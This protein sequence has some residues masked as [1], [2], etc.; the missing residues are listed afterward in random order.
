MDNKNWFSGIFGFGKKESKDSTISSDEENGEDN[1]KEVKKVDKVEDVG[2]EKRTSSREE[3]EINV[4]LNQIEELKKQLANIDNQID[5]TRGD[6]D[7]E[8]D[9]ARRQILEEIDKL[10]K[11]AGIEVSLDDVEYEKAEIEDR[12]EVRKIVDDIL[13][14]TYILEAERVKG[15]SGKKAKMAADLENLFG[16]DMVTTEDIGG[17]KRIK[18]IKFVE[19]EKEF[20]KLTKVDRKRKIRN[21]VYKIIG[22]ILTGV[23][24]GFLA[25]T[26]Y[27]LAA[28][29]F[30][31][32]AGGSL[33][34]NG[35]A[36]FAA[37]LDLEKTR[38]NSR[39]TIERDDYIR[40]KKAIDLARKV[41]KGGYK[42]GEAVVEL[43]EYIQKSE[44][45]SLEK[46]KAFKKMENVDKWVKAGAGFVGG[47]SAS[48]GSFL[49]A[50]GGILKEIM[51]KGFDFDGDG[52]LHALRKLKDGY[53]FVYNGADETTQ[54]ARKVAEKTLTDQGKT[55]T[56]ASI[57]KYAGE[58]M[59]KLT[60]LNL[61]GGG[62]GHMLKNTESVNRAI[63]T[64]LNSSKEYIQL[65]YALSG[66]IIASIMNGLSLRGMNKENTLDKD[67]STMF[68]ELTEKYRERSGM[69][70]EAK[71]K[72]K[73][74]R[75][76]AEE[77]K[78]QEPFYQAKEGDMI[79]I[80]TPIKGR[81]E[82]YPI[83][84]ELGELKSDDEN[85]DY[86]PT[87][88]NNEDQ[89]RLIGFKEEDI[90]KIIN[91]KSNLRREEF[92]KKANKW[93][94]IYYSPMELRLLEHYKANRAELYNKI[95]VDVEIPF[96]DKSMM[97]DLG[98]DPDKEYAVEK[99]DDEKNEL[100]LYPEDAPRVASK[101]I[102][103]K[104]TQILPHINLPT[105]KFYADSGK[106]EEIENKGSKTETGSSKS[107]EKIEDESTD[108]YKVGDVIRYKK[109]KDKARTKYDIVE[110]EIAI[111]EERT[112]KDG[113]KFKVYGVKDGSEFVDVYEMNVIGEKK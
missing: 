1:P 52:I 58:F 41:E 35:A 112:G 7:A 9:K 42:E 26:G 77:E 64:M 18:E 97:S 78:S 50:K 104:I 61:E 111:I 54:L 108:G 19:K 94:N 23:G 13:S 105:K 40:Y 59:K 88:I 96:K 79:F 45:E 98:L 25:L 39:L 106:K 21:S 110:G 76:K 20:E 99:F 56:E 90:K 74:A 71:E 5:T 92:N 29:P 93:E 15:L 57:D 91:S 4:V 43:L 32:G 2:L 70:K 14:G 27:G 47:M 8:R 6:L 44:Q 46:I 36:E 22:G 107:D 49:Y 55:L 51:N 30:V 95:G 16:D 65:K 60:T 31:F 28:S 3:G 11:T 68:K 113:K 17:K 62:L 67:R 100:V 63:L 84:Y 12:E 85:G 38:R 109:F 83:L 34:G 82:K 103:F 89:L 101:L 33:I 48:I 69:E 73:E 87:I 53:A 72:A 102:R 81:T 86:Y 37:A 80:D 66:G 24:G 10:S 75:K